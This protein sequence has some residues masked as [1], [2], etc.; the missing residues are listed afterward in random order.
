MRSPGSA[1]VALGAGLPDKPLPE[2][3]GT[4]HELTSQHTPSCLFV[5]PAPRSIRPPGGSAVTLDAAAAEEK[6]HFTNHGLQGFLPNH[7]TRVTAFSD[8]PSPPARRGPPAAGS[9]VPSARLR[10]SASLSRALPALPARARSPPPWP[11]ASTRTRRWPPMRITRPTAAASACRPEASAGRVSAAPSR[12]TRQPASPARRSRFVRL[13]GRSK[14]GGIIRPRTPRSPPPAR[15][16]GRTARALSAPTRP[17]RRPP[18]GSS[19]PLRR[20]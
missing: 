1:A 15:C 14:R 7:E 17:T 4:N 3:R 10:V 8:T 6:S 18:A 12:G 11:A 13:R 9:R 5:V 20:R 16:R 2:T 19:A